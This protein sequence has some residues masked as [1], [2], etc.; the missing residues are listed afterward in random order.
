MKPIGNRPDAIRNWMSQIRWMVPRRG[1]LTDVAEWTGNEVLHFG[2][3]LIKAAENGDASWEAVNAMMD[4][5]DADMDARTGLWGTN[6]G[7]SKEN[8]IIAA[9]AIARLYF[10]LNRPLKFPV[11]ISESVRGA[12]EAMSTG[13]SSFISDPGTESPLLAWLRCVDSALAGGI[14]CRLRG[15]APFNCFSADLVSGSCQRISVSD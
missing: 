9:G 15:K 6:R 13:T 2:G 5:L 12:L 14:P 10:Y 8:A 7:C 3:M 1:N 11:C 4:C